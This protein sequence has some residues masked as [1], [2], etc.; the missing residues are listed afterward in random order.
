M[1]GSIKA[2]YREIRPK[3]HSRKQVNHALKNQQIN[4]CKLL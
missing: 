4:A 2:D 1:I 3:K